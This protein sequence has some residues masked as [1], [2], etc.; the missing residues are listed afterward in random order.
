MNLNQTTDILKNTSPAG[1]NLFISA[2]PKINSIV[3]AINSEFNS[4]PKIESPV[5]IPNWNNRPEEDKAVISLNGIP[6]L[7][8][9]NVAAII[10]APGNGKSSVCEAAVA[11]Y[12]NKD[13][14]CLGLLVDSC[15]NGVIYVDFER[16]NIDVW[17]SFYRIARRAGKNN[18]Q[19]LNNVVIAGMRSIPRLKERLGELKNLLENNACGLLI[20]DG[21]GDMITDSNDL[22][23][24]IECRILLRE[25]A[26]KFK[27]SI[28]TTLHPNPNSLKPRGHIGSE[29]LREAECVL[30]IKNFENYKLLTTDF[31]HGKNRNSSVASSAYAWSDEN[32]MFVSTD[33]SIMEDSKTGAKD[34]AKRNKIEEMCTKVFFPANSYT[35]TEMLENIMQETNKSKSTA[36]RMIEDILLWKILNKGTDGNYRM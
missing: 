36:K 35:Y 31:E 28:L 22:P 4:I 14:D 27:L 10:A 13:A 33:A 6:F 23:E 25:L 1:N 2:T 24:A 8:A 26:V 15:I 5:F 20:L 34:L 30:V 11:S 12:I 3:D 16:T 29:I 21:A 19:D 9:G 18:G 17:N 7:T 32:K